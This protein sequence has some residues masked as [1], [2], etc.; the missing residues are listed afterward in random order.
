MLGGGEE[1][2]VEFQVKHHRSVKKT[3]TNNHLLKK[4]LT[5]PPFLQNSVALTA[6]IKK[7]PLETAVTL[8]QPP[9]PQKHP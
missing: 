5:W 8:H 6:K 4:T 1:D 7:N 2:T 3:V 9:T